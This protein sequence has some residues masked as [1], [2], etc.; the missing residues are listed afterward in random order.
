MIPSEKE[1]MVKAI[2][3]IQDLDIQRDTFKSK[4]YNTS[5]RNQKFNQKEY[6]DLNK[7]Y[8]MGKR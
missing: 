8:K 2:D 5:R 4:R 6:Y 7:I 3:N 1:S